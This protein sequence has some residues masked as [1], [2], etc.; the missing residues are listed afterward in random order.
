MQQQE[1][2]DYYGFEMWF[3]CPKCSKETKH[4]WYPAD[5]FMESDDQFP[6]GEFE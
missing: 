6:E 1:K 4:I 3:Q 2:E 5:Y